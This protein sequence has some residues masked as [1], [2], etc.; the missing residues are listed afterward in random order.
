MPK[1]ILCKQCDIGC[2]TEEQAR[3]HIEETGHEMDQGREVTPI[4][5]KNPSKE[6]LDFI[7]GVMYGKRKLDS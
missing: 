1:L 4:D 2:F 7:K 3:K 6:D 5:L